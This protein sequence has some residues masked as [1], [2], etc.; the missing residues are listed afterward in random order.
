MPIFTWNAVSSASEYLLQVT[1]VSGMRDA[2]ITDCQGTTCFATPFSGLA[3]GPV[4]WPI[5]A[6]NIAG[7]GPWSGSSFTVDRLL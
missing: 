1:D 3:P 7:S 6:V 4:S 5:Q 2:R